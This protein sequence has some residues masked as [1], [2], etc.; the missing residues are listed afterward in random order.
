MNSTTP[1]PERVA[2]LG[3]GTMGHGIAQQFALHGRAVACW[4]QQSQALAGLAPAVR[5][6]LEIASE[7]GILD[8]PAIDRVLAN[9]SCCESLADAVAGADL[10]VEAIAEDL[11]AKRLLHA[12]AQTAA[13]LDAV[14]ATNTSAI[15]VS[16]IASACPDPS[17]VIGT[18]WFNPPHIIPAVE[19][20][21]GEFTTDDVVDRVSDGLRSVDRIPCRTRNTPGFVANRIQFA[22]IAEAFRCLEDGVADAQTIDAITRN[23]FGPRL[24]AF[25][26]FEVAD[27]A[28]LDVYSSILD[29]LTQ[30]LEQA[31]FSPTDELRS[32]VAEGRL[33]VKAGAGIYDYPASGGGA[34]A[35]RDRALYSVL[36]RVNA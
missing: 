31:S 16:S 24:A 22:M 9:L 20:I 21:P 10:I 23:T 6:N 29:Y 33:G 30:H 34:V 3:L 5:R 35:D 18:H 8:A 13:S 12:A 7:F 28:G 26:V 14:L 4:D 15:D 1:W 25:G 19:V 17:R 27:L 11:E 32:A 2:V 36:G